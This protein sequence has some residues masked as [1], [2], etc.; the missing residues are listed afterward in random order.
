M[1]TLLLLIC[2]DL[3]HCLKGFTE[4]E[5][6]MLKPMVAISW[7]QRLE[8]KAFRRVFGEDRFSI[9]RLDADIALSVVG[10]TAILVTRY[11]EFVPLL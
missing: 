5:A 6:H 10:A 2:F 4:I 8:V 7:C 1:H 3:P 9:V 11:A